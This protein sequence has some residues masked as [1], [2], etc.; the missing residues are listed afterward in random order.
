MSSSCASVEVSQNP[1]QDATKNCQ[2]PLAQLE[3]QYKLQLPVGLQL[4]LYL[5]V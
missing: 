1:V 4:C 5:P 3:R 2:A